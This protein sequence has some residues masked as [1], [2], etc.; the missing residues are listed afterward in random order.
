M[1]ACL[2]AHGSVLLQQ[3]RLCRAAA[4]RRGKSLY[5]IDV[6]TGNRR[7][8]YSKPMAPFNQHPGGYT[9]SVTAGLR[10]C[11]LSAQGDAYCWQ[12]GEPGRCL[13]VR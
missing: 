6:M 1:H 7:Y 5:G 2:P 13:G 3:P 11:A 12:F 4:R 10:D 8:V 9:A